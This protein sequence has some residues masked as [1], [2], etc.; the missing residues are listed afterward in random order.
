MPEALQM[1]CR[2]NDKVDMSNVSCIKPSMMPFPPIMFLEYGFKSRK[3]ARDTVCSKTWPELGTR[4]KGLTSTF[5]GLSFQF[6]G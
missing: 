6:G 1:R 2:S 4:T 5:I 3:N